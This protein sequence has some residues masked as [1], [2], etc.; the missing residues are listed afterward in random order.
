MYCPNCKSNNIILFSEYEGTS[1][2]KCYDC[3]HKWEETEMGDN[4]PVFKK[5]EK[6]K[7]YKGNKVKIKIDTG[8]YYYGEILHANNYD[9]LYKVEYKKGHQ[10]EKDTFKGEQLELME[11]NIKKLSYIRPK[12]QEEHDKFKDIGIVPKAKRNDIINLLI[13]LWEFLKDKTKEKKK[14]K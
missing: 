13:D 12:E 2:W 7:F 5:G 4:F 1:F 6:M 10:Y 11:T 9:N 14:W 3:S 8:I